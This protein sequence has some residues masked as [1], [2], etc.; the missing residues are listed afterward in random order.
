MVSL[1][2]DV[3]WIKIYV[4]LSVLQSSLQLPIFLS[5]K[6]T[7]RRQAAGIVQCRRMLNVRH[8]SLLDILRFI[9]SLGEERPKAWIYHKEFVCQDC[10]CSL[11]WSRATPSCCRRPTCGR[12]CL[13]GSASSY[14]CSSSG[15]SGSWRDSR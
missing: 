4:L 14:S 9:F 13:A 3:N 8:A 11:P 2:P 7:V 15:A 10:C 6:L 12:R 5:G 1:I